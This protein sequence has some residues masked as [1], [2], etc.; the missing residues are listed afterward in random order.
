[1]AAT[2]VPKN[3][4]KHPAKKGTSGLHNAL[5]NFETALVK[6]KG[7]HYVLRLYIAGSTTRSMQALENVKRVC[8]SEL[9]GRYQLEVI[10]IYQQPQLAKGDQI[11]AAPTL[12]KRLPLPLRT[13][14]GTLSN[15]DQVL[16]GLDLR[17][18]K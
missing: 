14:I 12:V 2:N 10:D 9:K 17:A 1:M 5:A 11:I 8:E 15:V 16:V 6:R 4:G 18:R 3:S 7:E 13:M